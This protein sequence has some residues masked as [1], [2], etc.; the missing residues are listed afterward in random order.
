MSIK[1]V[2]IE[3]LKQIPDERGTVK[4]FLADTH[5]PFAECY[6]TTI[7]KNVIK[8]FHGY[9]TK[10]LW[11]C[12]PIGMVK[13]VLWEQ[14][15]ENYDVI[16]TGENK[17]QRIFIPHGVFNAFYGIADFSLVAVLATEKFNEETTMRILASQGPYDWH[18]WNGK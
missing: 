6:F 17:Y 9:K 11:Y 14:G 5:F 3:D 15:T 13:L 18:G 10:D 16:V 4:H 1:G 8:G 7:Y 12:V 2:I